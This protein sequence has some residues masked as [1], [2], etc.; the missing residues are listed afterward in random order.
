M[1]VR[2]RNT[3]HVVA[4][5][6]FDGI[7]P[8]HL[9]VPCVVF[10]EN[11][12]AGGVPVFDFRVCAL[13]AGTL[14]TTAGF[15]IA[16]THGL[17]ALDDAHT[18][19]VPSWRDPDEAPPAELLEA[20]RRA[21]ARG[22]QLVG[23]CLGAFVLAAAGILDGRTATTHW[24]WA[25]DFARRFPRVRLDPDVLY[26][27]DG[28]VLTSAGTAAGLDCCL[29]VLRGLC[30]AQAANYVARRLVVSPHRQGGQAQYIE[31]PVPPNLRGDRL[32]GLLEW[33]AGNLDMPHTLDSLAERALMSRR[34][35]TRRFRLATGATVGA[36][37]LAQRLARA[38]QLLESSDQSVE[39]IAA[40]AGF[41]STAS[42]RQHFQEAFR[43][44]P[45][46]WRREFRGV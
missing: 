33:V 28:D 39:A 1:S 42:L 7:S 22:A 6:A 24:A 14:S 12:D 40:S 31:Q 35:F 4:A 19:I 29:H 9:S 21:H 46:A 45:S 43:T 10:G 11:R 36:W 15:S 8:F 18:I 37:L 27:D 41:G 44:S 25:G 34:T 5:I 30:G 38:Q 23:L 20:L 3:P 13:E 16:A 17:K 26:I 32:S 2:D